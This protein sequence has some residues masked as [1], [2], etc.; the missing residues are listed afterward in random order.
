MIESNHDLVLSVGHRDVVSDFPCSVIEQN[1]IGI[2]RLKL[3]PNLLMNAASSWGIRQFAFNVDSGPI[4]NL[5]LRL[6]DWQRLVR[7]EARFR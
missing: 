6:V 4:L 7:L 3:L 2:T 5:D 1:H